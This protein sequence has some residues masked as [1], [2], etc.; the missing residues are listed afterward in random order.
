MS[1]VTKNVPTSATFQDAA[2][3]GNVE[4]L[5][6]FIEMGVDVDMKNEVSSNVLYT[7]SVVASTTGMLISRAI[8]HFFLA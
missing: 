7:P 4:S 2:F 3:A 5:K 8:V 1:E 6:E